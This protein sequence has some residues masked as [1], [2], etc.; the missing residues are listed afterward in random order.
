MQQIRLDLL[1]PCQP[2]VEQASPLLSDHLVRRRL[3]RNIL[4]VKRVAVL[5]QRPAYLF[6]LLLRG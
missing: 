2:L 3:A 4:P 5:A 6:P 1:S